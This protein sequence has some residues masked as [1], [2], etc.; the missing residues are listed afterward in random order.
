HGREV[1]G[2]VGLGLNQVKEGFEDGQSLAEMAD[3]YGDGRG[4][5]VE[6]LSRLVTDGIDRMERAGAVDT[7]VADA[8]EELAAERIEFMVDYERGD[9]LPAGFDH[10]RG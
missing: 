3:E 8:F 9:P 1:L 4:E 2:V 10:D 7:K 6:T 5:L